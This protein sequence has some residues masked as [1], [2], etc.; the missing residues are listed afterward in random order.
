MKMIL[1]T[2]TMEWPIQSDGVGYVGSINDGMRK[3]VMIGL[4]KRM[5]LFFWA[6]LLFSNS[7]PLVNLA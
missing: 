7:D 6:A 1:T 3:N 4:W 5:A 2:F